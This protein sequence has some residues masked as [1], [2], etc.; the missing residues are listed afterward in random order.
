V[1]EWKKLLVVVAEFSGPEAEV[2]DVVPLATGAVLEEHHLVAG[3]VVVTD[4]GTVPINPRG[5]K[6]RM[7][8]RDHFLNDSL[9]PLAIN[10]NM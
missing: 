6:Q 8:L 3:V 5:E 10:Y 7:L 2:L 9:D 1:F 4:P